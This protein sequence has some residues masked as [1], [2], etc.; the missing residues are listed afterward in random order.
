MGEQEGRGTGRMVG[1]GGECSEEVSRAGGVLSSYPD[2]LPQGEASGL[3]SIWGVRHE[4]GKGV[5]C[6]F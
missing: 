6:G 1:G 2:S 3:A 4:E 5:F